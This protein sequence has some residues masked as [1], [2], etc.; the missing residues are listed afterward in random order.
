MERTLTGVAYR[1]VTRSSARRACEPRPLPSLPFDS[2]H[3]GIFTPLHPPEA[4][5]SAEMPAR[6]ARALQ[7]LIAVHLM[8]VAHVQVG[9]ALLLQ[10]ESFSGPGVV[11]EG[12]DRPKE[13]GLSGRA[14]W[15][16]DWS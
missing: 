1:E 3:T 6:E 5:I 16:G 8:S 7:S 14:K 13:I 10:L 12:Q 11:N 2:E 15:P 4:A 9:H